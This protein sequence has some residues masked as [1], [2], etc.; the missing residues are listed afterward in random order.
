MTVI[1][2]GRRHKQAHDAQHS[3]IRVRRGRCKRC[4]T[5]I[6]VLPAWSLPYTHYSLEAR[7]EAADRYIESASLEQAAPPVQNPNR[8]ADAAT[9]RRWFQRRLTSWWNC[10]S[11]AFLLVPTI[12]AWDWTAAVRILVPEVKPT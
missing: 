12:L 10:L 4:G 3:S 1:G 2:H 11:N 5:T 7:R 6:T 9:F 8:V